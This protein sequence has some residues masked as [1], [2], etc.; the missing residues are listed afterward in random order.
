MFKQFKGVFFWFLVGLFLFAVSVIVFIFS[1]NKGLAKNDLKIGLISDIH[2]GNEET[3]FIID[4]VGYGFPRQYKKLFSD[5]LVEMKITNV[6]FVIANGDNTNTG[7]NQYADTLVQIANEN[8]MEVIWVKGNHDREKTEVMKNFGV[9]GRYYY[10]ID[11]GPWRI[12]VLDSTEID[13]TNAGGIS[14]EQ[15]TWLRKSLETEKNVIIAMH[16]P[17]YIEPKLENLHDSYGAFQKIIEEAGNVKY[18]FSGH[19]HT[20]DYSKKVNGI[21]YVIIKSLTLEKD[22]PNFKIINLKN[23]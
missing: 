22:V 20:V 4:G 2:A 1:H 7:K 9:K 8:N 14:L 3:R 23:E 19:Y 5:A 6:N 11:K 17:I 18:V 10:F 13:A 15:T 16:H 21:E 12:I